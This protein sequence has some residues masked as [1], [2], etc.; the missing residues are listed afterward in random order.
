[1]N[2][3]EAP[4]AKTVKGFTKQQGFS[5]RMLLNKADGREYGVELAYGVKVTPTLY[6][7]GSDGTVLYGHSGAL[8]PEQLLEVAAQAR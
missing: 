7:V 2:L 4:R 6:L 3:D 5:F 8:S 1:M